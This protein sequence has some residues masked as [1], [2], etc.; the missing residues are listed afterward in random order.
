[1]LTFLGLFLP[2]DVSGHAAELRLS[3]PGVLSHGNGIAPSSADCVEIKKLFL[4]AKVKD[5]KRD[6]PPSRGRHLNSTR[7]GGNL[8]DAKQT[9]K[10]K[11]SN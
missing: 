11:W 9:K 5:L 8:G 4:V 7:P 10:L 2:T 6:V 1:M 3:S